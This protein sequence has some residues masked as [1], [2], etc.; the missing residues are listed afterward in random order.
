MVEEIKVLQGKATY[1]G[2]YSPSPPIVGNECFKDIS[3][4]KRERKR[5][6]KRESLSWSL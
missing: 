4:E 3:I 1:W 2:I 5:M 6:R